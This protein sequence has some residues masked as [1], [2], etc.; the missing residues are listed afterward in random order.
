[1][2]TLQWELAII[3]SSES[4]HGPTDTRHANGPNGKD[5]DGVGE[6]ILRLYTDPAGTVVGFAWSTLSAS[7]F[8]SPDDEHLVIGRLA[9]HADTPSDALYP[10]NCATPSAAFPGR[11]RG[12][13]K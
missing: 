9:E 3:D 1:P 5:H 11:C 4:G 6:G 13:L 8:K 10:G 7:K 2:G 12:A